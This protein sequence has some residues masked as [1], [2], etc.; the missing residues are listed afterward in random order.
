MHRRTLLRA[1]L[2]TPAALALPALGGPA[3]ARPRLAGVMARGLD[4]PWN[5][6]FLPGGDALVSERDTGRIVRVGRHGGRRTVGHVPG[7]VPNVSQ[8]GEGGLLGLA[9]HPGF[10]RNHWVYAYFSSRTDNR[11]VR[12][13]YVDGR[14]GSPHVIVTGIRKAIHHNGGGLA[15]GPSGRLFV[16]TGDAE[17]PES[18]HNRS[19]L[20]GKVLRV[21]AD[22]SVPRSNPF[23]NRVWTYGHRNPE[24]ITFAD[25]GTLWE[26]E[27][28]QDTWDE[29]NR[30]VEGHD[31]GWPRLEGKDGRGGS[32]DPLAQWRPDN[33]SPSG[34]AVLRGRAWLGALRGECLWSVRLHGPRRGHVV[35]HL[36]GRLGRIRA[37]AA[38]PDGS[39]WIGTSNR[40]G[41]ATPGPDDDRI[42]RVTFG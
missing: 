9:L 23:G 34:V 21:N 32:S 26:S 14:L 28:G 33:C 17:N 31:Y 41:R 37:V 7:V 3:E 2:V 6:A 29:L 5:I 39:L 42:L 30:I 19:S 13:R 35:R 24:G 18:A 16:S 12:M 36:H 25:D 40:D 20:N 11:V 4:V 38:A 8:G 15:F 1:G 22:G 27:F 10:R